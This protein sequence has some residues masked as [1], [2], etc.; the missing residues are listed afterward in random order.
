MQLFSD[1]FKNLSWEDLY[2]ENLSINYKFDNLFGR[3]NYTVQEHVPLKKVNE[4]QLNLISNHG[5]LL[6]FKM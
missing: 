4:Q 1:D 2:D 5:L 3:V 6:T